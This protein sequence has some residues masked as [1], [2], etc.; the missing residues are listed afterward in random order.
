MRNSN[1]ARDY[2]KTGLPALCEGRGKRGMAMKRGRKAWL[3]AN[4]AVTLRR[5]SG[6]LLR[7]AVLARLYLQSIDFK[8]Y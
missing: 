2:C 8:G 4:E 3:V 7:V 6:A 1:A 5:W